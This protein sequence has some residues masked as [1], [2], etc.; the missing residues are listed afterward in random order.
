[1][2][3][4]DMDTHSCDATKRRLLEAAGKVIS[5]KGFRHATTRE[6]CR[7]AGANNAA[8]NY[9]FGDKLGMYNAVLRCAFYEGL[10]L[11]PL[12]MGLAPDAPAAERL[13]AF[14]RS[15]FH[16]IL[17]DGRPS[18]FSLL[19]AREMLDPTPAIESLVREAITPIWQTLRGIIGEILGVQPENKLVAACASSVIGQ[20]QHYIIA[21]TTLRLIRP[22]LSLSSDKVEELAEHVT[23]FS[24]A[25]LAYCRE[26]PETKSPDKS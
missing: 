3:R 20:C 16:R 24:L 22:D 15:F 8:V 1:M 6:I 18:W 13:R 21:R 17:S 23:R 26:H 5:E 4:T 25:A 10:R 2:E 11:Y 12:D 7:L 9:H 14:V 19:M